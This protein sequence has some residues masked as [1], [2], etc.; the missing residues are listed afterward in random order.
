MYVFQVLI[1]CYV[2]HFKTLSEYASFSIGSWANNI[3]ISNVGFNVKT[4]ID[5][6]DI[7]Y[8]FTL[9][10]DTKISFLQGML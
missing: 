10:I 2:F 6:V 9:L 3:I 5:N 1:F 7:I 4:C 8:L